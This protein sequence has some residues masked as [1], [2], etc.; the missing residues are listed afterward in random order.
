MVY[1]VL[2]FTLCQS[3]IV[4]FILFSYVNFLPVDKVIEIILY[5]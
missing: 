2:K 5:R 3:H 1:H 4:K